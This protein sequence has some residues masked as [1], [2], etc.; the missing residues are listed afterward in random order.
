MLWRTTRFL[1][2]N[3]IPSRLIC[4]RVFRYSIMYILPRPAI[5]QSHPIRNFLVQTK[6]KFNNLPDWLG[7]CWVVGYIS[8]YD[9]MVY[10]RSISSGVRLA[11]NGILNIWI[12][13]NNIHVMFPYFCSSRKPSDNYLDQLYC[14]ALHHFTWNTRCSGRNYLLC[15]PNNLTKHFSSD[16][17]PVLTQLNA[18]EIISGL[19]IHCW[20]KR[21]WWSFIQNLTLR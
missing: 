14:C 6:Q 9:P 3:K 19:L 12:Y 13:G 18:K 2:F 20:L 4:L 15:W 8:E 10:Y 11:S 21:N 17:E 1:F 16:P 5:P 7:D